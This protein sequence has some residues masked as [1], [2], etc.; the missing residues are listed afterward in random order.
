M[1]VKQKYTMQV[2]YK[3]IETQ[4][5]WSLHPIEA[6]PPLASPVMPHNYITSNSQKVIIFNL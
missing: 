3:L 4:D 2:Q 6:P 5:E 1:R